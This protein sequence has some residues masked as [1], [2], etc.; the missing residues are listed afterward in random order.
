MSSK[1]NQEQAK[2]DQGKEDQDKEEQVKPAASPDDVVVAQQEGVAGAQPARKATI[3]SEMC[4]HRRSSHHA[5][6][7]EQWKKNKEQEKFQNE[8]IL[9]N[10]DKCEKDVTTTIEYHSGVC[11]HGEQW[12]DPTLG[13][14]KKWNEKRANR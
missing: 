4:N 5:P 2:E 12:E 8:P 13:I 1:D 6:S 14:S 7:F 11:T 9:F 3:L 10:C